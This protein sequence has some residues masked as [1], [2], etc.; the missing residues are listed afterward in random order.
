MKEASLYSVSHWQDS[1]AIADLSLYNYHEM[2]SHVNSRLFLLRKKVD[3]FLHIL[4][5]KTFIPLYTMV[6]F[7]R[8]PYHVVVERSRRQRRLVT[9]LLAVGTVIS[10]CAIGVLVARQVDPGIF[11]KCKPFLLALW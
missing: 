11:L 3:N 5:P 1:H 6:A 4:F 7:T 8:I 9:G 10:V 2:R